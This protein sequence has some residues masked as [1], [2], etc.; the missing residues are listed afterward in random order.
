M[1]AGYCEPCKPTQS[2]R[3]WARAKLIA[4]FF[5]VILAFVILTA[6][7]LLG[8]IILARI[9]THVRAAKEAAASR[10]RTFVH[11]VS[12]RLWGP[13][14]G[15]NVSSG[16][17]AAPAE[18]AAAVAGLG[19]TKSA[20]KRLTPL[21]ARRKAQWTALKRVGVF[22]FVP[23]R[24]VIENIQIISSFDTRRDGW[25]SRLVSQLA[26]ICRKIRRFIAWANIVV[27]ALAV[28]AL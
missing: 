18:S 21:Q 17:E 25:G 23:I 11:H 20:K 9:E 16:E 12:H 10:S 3:R 15:G 8:P 19:E 27:I 7:F 22:A 28:V 14:A 26:H 2:L 6:P 1:Q 5:F 13:R 4:V 24:L